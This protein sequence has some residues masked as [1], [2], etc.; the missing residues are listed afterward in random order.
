M[1]YIRPIRILFLHPTFAFGGAERTTYNLL[2][3]LDREKFRITLLTSKKLLSHYSSLELESVLFVEDLGLHVWFDTLRHFLRD[4]RIIS[5]VIKNNEF[6]IAFGMMHYSASLLASARILY[7]TRVKV[8]SSPRGPSSVYLNTCIPNKKEKVFLRILF[9]L[10]CRFSDGLIVPSRGTKDDCVLNFG[11][12]TERISVIP[13]SVD[14]TGIRQK[15]EEPTGLSFPGDVSIITTSGRLSVEKNLDFLF[16]VFSG[17]RKERRVKLLVIGEGPERPGLESL[18]DKLGI[19]DDV[20]FLGFQS[21]PYKYIAASDVFVHTCIVEGFG[22]SIIE[23]MACNVPVVSID[24]PCGPGE[25]IRHNENGLLIEPGDSEGLSKAVK[26][27]L[28]ENNMRKRLAGKGLLTASHY[29]VER[30]VTSYDEMFTRVV[31]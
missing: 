6:D 31:G 14:S 22:N 20:L 15:K 18:A 13:N 5:K 30:M 4:T 12:K 24:C 25:I 26:L 21:N 9:S 2:R 23:A 8:I 29:S 11:A 17:I 19:R 28:N 7:R 1:A 16:H 3:D 27:L 10:F